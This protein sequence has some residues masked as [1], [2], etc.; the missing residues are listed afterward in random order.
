M[1]ILGDIAKGLACAALDGLDNALTKAKLEDANYVGIIFDH[2]NHPFYDIEIRNTL[3]QTIL[4]QIGTFLNVEISDR[5]KNKTWDCYV[6][7]DYADGPAWDA[8]IIKK[9]NITIKYGL[10]G[11]AQCAIAVSGFDCGQIAEGITSILVENDFDN[12][13]YYFDNIPFH[14]IEWLE[15]AENSVSGRNTSSKSKLK[16]KLTNIDGDI[17]T[18]GILLKKLDEI[19]QRKAIFTKPESLY[20]D[21]NPDE[22]PMISDGI[23][24]IKWTCEN[25]FVYFLYSKNQ[26]DLYLSFI[27][28]EA[29]STLHLEFGET[30][31]DASWDN[32]GVFTLEDALNDLKKKKLTIPEDFVKHLVFFYQV[33]EKMASNLSDNGDYDDDDEYDDEDESFVSEE[34]Q[35]ALEIL[36]LEEESV[37]IDEI[38]KA[39]RKLAKE[40]HPDRMQGLT[41]KMKEIA[42][43]EFTKL[44]Q[45]YELLLDFYSEE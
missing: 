7:Y 22:Y 17:Q 31:F 2:S 44:K 3:V 10:C 32:D 29:G 12:I 8:F 36:E 35:E 28:L 30:E 14:E 21:D 9:N 13:Q 39:Y 45:A 4:L 1:G 38:K 18:A 25:G 15:N 42:V 5:T 24:T 16:L 37:S 26:K 34:I 33:L 41:P 11:M 40:F 43:K 19:I 27:S 23:T 6:N 20:F